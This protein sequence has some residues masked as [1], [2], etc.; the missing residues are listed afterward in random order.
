MVEAI[1]INVFPNTLWLDTANP[2]MRHL[3]Y[4][5]LEYKEMFEQTFEDSI[6]V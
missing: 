6:W 5:Q 4:F 3:T 1:F 2:N